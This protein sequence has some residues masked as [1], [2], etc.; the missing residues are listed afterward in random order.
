MAEHHW[1]V[2][3]RPAIQQLLQLREE[4][5][6]QGLHVFQLLV[7]TVLLERYLFVG[8]DSNP[9][10]QGGKRERYLCALYLSRNQLLSSTQE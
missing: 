10:L 8:S 7:M 9:G 4:P 2:A 6:E 5:S 1:H 3:G